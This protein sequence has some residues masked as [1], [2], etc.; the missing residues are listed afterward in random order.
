[1]AS[2]TFVDNTTVIYASWLNAVN[3]AVYTDI[4]LI[5]TTLALK[6]NLISPTFTTPV[7]GVATATSVNKITITQPATGATLTIPD[8]TTATVSGTNTGDQLAFKTISVSGQSD[9]VADTITDTL[10]LV[11]GSGMTITTNAGTDTITLT[12]PG[13]TGLSLV[14]T[15]TPTVAANID[16]LTTFSATYDNYIIV[17]DGITVGTNDFINIRLAAA[18]TADAGSNYYF[19]LAA[20]STAFTASATSIQVGPAF[21]SAGKGGSFTFEIKNVNDATNLKT[22]HARTVGQ[23]AATPGYTSI[24]SDGVY[25]AAN[26]VTGFRLF[27]NAGSNFAATGKVRVYGYNNT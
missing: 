1:M 8:G 27:L 16:F 25:I 2:T 14:A 4:P 20:S 26:A 21:T 6:A 11:A 24:Y 19:T 15:L 23:T 18:G 12:A 9:V 5:N 22:V 13:I 10:T 17:G 3:T 7:L